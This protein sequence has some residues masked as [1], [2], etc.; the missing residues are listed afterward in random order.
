MK[1]IVTDIKKLSIPCEPL[2]FLTEQGVMKEEGQEIIAAIKE[3]MEK[4]PDLIALAAPQIGIK[5]RIFCIRFNDVIKTFIN[6]VIKKVSTESIIRIE[7]CASLPNTD[8][9]ICRPKE[10]EIVYYTDEFKYE[11]NK[12]LDAAAAIFEQ[13]YQL[14]E[15]IVPGQSLKILAPEHTLT[16]DDINNIIASSHSG[17]GLLFP[18][19]TEDEHITSE[20]IPEIAKYLASYCEYFKALGESLKDSTDEAIKAHYKQLKFADD[21]IYGKVL[22]VD[23]GPKLNREQRRAAEKR[24][25]QLK[26]KKAGKK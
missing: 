5:K 1:R 20:D 25:K 22:I 6:P 13:Q 14:L 12:L 8:I 3:A 17:G 19:E 23:E 15:G 18:V 7:T 9:V 26:A 4:K 16:V 10:I 11:D 24:A 2:E 21:V